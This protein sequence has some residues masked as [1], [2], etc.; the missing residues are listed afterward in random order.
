MSYLISKNDSDFIN[1]VLKF[2]S[3]NDY[4]KKVSI[5]LYEN[6]KRINT[7]ES[8]SDIFN[9]FLMHESEN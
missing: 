7:S 8:I 6:F 1:S 4:L 5:A 2:S 3:D 9:R